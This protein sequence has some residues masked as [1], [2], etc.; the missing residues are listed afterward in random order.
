MNNKSTAPTD[1]FSETLQM[2]AEGGSQTHD[3]ASELHEMVFLCQLIAGARFGEECAQDPD[4]VIRLV[5]FLMETKENVATQEVLARD[6][7][8][9]PI[10][11]TEDARIRE[12]VDWQ[13]TQTPNTMSD[14]D[15]AVDLDLESVEP[16]NNVV[17]G[18]PIGTEDTANLNNGSLVG[19]GAALL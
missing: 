14:T 13:S 11:S 6:E 3:A 5:G 2:I 17:A 18:A 9:Q 10:E 15:P 7:D 8:W 4:T 12:S 16:V 19:E 1:K